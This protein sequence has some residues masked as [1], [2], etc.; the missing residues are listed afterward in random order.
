MYTITAGSD[1]DNIPA[2]GTPDYTQELKSA[3]GQGGGQ[4]FSGI[5]YTSIKNGLLQI[6]NEIAAVNS[7]FAS[8]SLP[9][10]SLAQGTFANQIYIGMFRP[11]ATDNP[12]W[13]GNLKQYQFGA[14]GTVNNPTLFLADAN[15]KPALSSTTGFVTP[16]AVS[17]WTTKDA[18]KLPD[19]I[20]PTGGFW[21]KQQQGQGQGFDSPDGEVVEKGGIAQQIRLANLQDNYTT[22]PSSPRTV[23]TCTGTCASAASPG[24]SLTQFATTNA[25][26][27]QAA[28]GITGPTST[29][30]SIARTGN[31][32]T[33]VLS[34]APTPALTNG[35]SVTVSG[36]A[37]VELNG[38]FTITLV[39]A[40]TFTYT[41][42]ESP[43][44]PST[45]T[46]TASIPSSPVPLL[47]LT[48]T[49]ATTA[50]FTL[51]AA[52]ASAFTN[53][54]KVTILGAGQVEYTGAQTLTKVNSTTYTYTITPGPGAAAGGGNATDAGG[55][56]PTTVTS[57][58]LS[59]IGS[60]APFA[61]TVTATISAKNVPATYTVG[62][63]VIVSNVVPGG[64]DG[65]FVI[66]AKGTVGNG[67]NQH[68]T[69]SYVINTSPASPA[70]G[71]ISADPSISVAI[72]AGGLTHTT[73]CSGATP[74]A[75][76]TVSVKTATTHPF[77]AGQS[78]TISGTPGARE[79]A[80]IGTF[81][82]AAPVT[83][84]TFAVSQTITTTPPCSPSAS[85]VSVSTGAASLDLTSLINWVRGDDDIGDE[86]SPDP[87]TITIRPSVHGDV[88]HSSPAVVNYTSTGTSSCGGTSCVVVFYG[89]NDGMFH[90]V[91]GNQPGG[92][93]VGSST[94]GQELWSFVA[95]EFFTKLSRLY[96]NSPQVQLA[97]TPSGITPTPTPKDYYFDGGTGV[98]QNAAG[99]QTYLFLS[100][101][102]GGR[103]IYALDVSDPTNPKMLWK[104]SNADFPELGYTW[105]SPKAA[106][107]RGYTN[108]VVIF[109]GGYDPNED[110]EPPTADTMGRGIFILDATTGGL[111]WS[112]TYSS[113]GATSTCTGTCTLN[114]MAYGIAADITVLNRD[115]DPTGYSD[116]LYAADLGGNIWRIDLEPA[117]YGTIGAA[118]RRQQSNT[119]EHLAD[120]K[121][122]RARW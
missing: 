8:P 44:T 73:S 95:P 114:D 103:I 50:Q 48:R 37:N 92:A 110:N 100:A 67:A 21:V 2:S 30:S 28:F 26:L 25:N 89:S 7:V 31:V 59:A 98:Y 34:A 57:V 35:Q 69:F 87:G 111:V 46:Y 60:T 40:T 76:D 101:R 49:N 66:T 93:S 86:L 32:V 74:S 11:D 81:T 61:A 115:G 108:P 55:L 70:T 29:V 15:G 85:G 105:S 117:G 39:S 99:T 18:T 88:L 80:Y 104:K 24:A 20:S 3:A 112:A 106:F 72:A 119:A 83:T 116:R 102:R 19:N 5:D 1:P 94:P 118:G 51:A 41:I 63:N 22:N 33:M 121:I 82:V 16:G 75:T 9:T 84:T 56:N 4:A 27:T 68:G 96:Q 107:V 52:N 53:G 38:T 10:S 14:T 13:V 77:T 64:Y 120:Y 71:S 62:A 78:I 45:G 23:Y 36:A 79:T 47:T 91:N 54:Q 113:G 58:A 97:T 43:P 109:G 90:A 17:F 65:T 12:R 42:I 122:R 6:F